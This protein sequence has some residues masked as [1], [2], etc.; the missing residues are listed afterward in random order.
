[1]DWI[2]G[3]S[4]IF[5]AVFL[6]PF[7]TQAVLS[8]EDPTVPP[9]FR[10]SGSLAEKKTSPLCIYIYMLYQQHIY[11]CINIDIWLFSL[12]ILI[13]WFGSEGKG[14]AEQLELQRYYIVCDRYMYIVHMYIYIHCTWLWK[15]LLCRIRQH[16][17][18]FFNDS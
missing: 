14:Y 6:P 16:Q 1:M 9:V 2:W 13:V 5:W 15:I 4:L 12:I 11:V 7:W 8:A 18:N 17:S 3:V 10:N